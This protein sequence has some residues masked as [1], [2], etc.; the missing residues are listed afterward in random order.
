MLSGFLQSN[1]YP[2]AL[3][4]LVRHI[5]VLCHHNVMPCGFSS[6]NV[7]LISILMRE[8]TY[9]LIN[10]I[11]MNVQMMVQYIMSFIITNQG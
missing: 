6:Q 5:S 7:R 11:I 9:R 1:P 4:D 3:L 8:K 2:R 10:Q